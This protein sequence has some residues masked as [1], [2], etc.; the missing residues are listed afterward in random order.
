M[1]INR[2][3]LLKQ[4][5][6]WVAGG[7]VAVVALLLMGQCERRSSAGDVARAEERVRVAYADSL[8]K[9]RAVVRADSVFVRDTVRLTKVATKY[10]MLRDSVLVRLTDTVL[11]RQTIIA[12]DTAIRACR[13]AVNSC[14]AAKAARDSLIVT[15]GQQRAA[16]ANLFRA[17]LRRANPRVTP[18]L[19]ALVDPNGFTSGVGR[20][21]LEIRVLGPV[22]LAGALEATRI[23]NHTDTRALVGLRVTF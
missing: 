19:E 7:V 15:L 17:R 1:T 23:P 21:G 4:P 20:A 16:D 22:R 12:A 13:E 11:V 8:A 6:V 3:G 14:A 10:T 2:A 9:A 5:W 18:Y